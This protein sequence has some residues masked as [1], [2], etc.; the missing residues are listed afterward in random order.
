[1]VCVVMMCVHV[2]HAHARSGVLNI[3]L[4]VVLTA[5]CIVAIAFCIVQLRRRR[6]HRKKH[7]TVTVHF[8]TRSAHD[9]NDMTAALADGNEHSHVVSANGTHHSLV[10]EQTE[11]VSI[12]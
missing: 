8:L 12:V 5:I 2:G 11:K 3:I 10:T 4:G 7:E 6:R 1:M 9:N